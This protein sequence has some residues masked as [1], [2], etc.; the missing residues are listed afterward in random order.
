MNFVTGVIVYACLWW[1]IF[2][3]VLPI[4]VERDPKP[5]NGNDPGA[6]VKTHLKKKVLI[7][8]LAALILWGLYGYILTQ[9]HW[10]EGA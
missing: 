8:S 10:L 9:T 4:G 7:T 3:M 5:Q 6:P 2:F 1:V